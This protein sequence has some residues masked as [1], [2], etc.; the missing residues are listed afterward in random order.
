MKSKELKDEIITYSARFV[1]E[2]EAFNAQDNYDINIH[3]EGFLIPILSKAFEL[4]LVDLNKERKT[5]Q[6]LI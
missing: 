1:Q 2:V 6:R 3:S 5:F 4:D